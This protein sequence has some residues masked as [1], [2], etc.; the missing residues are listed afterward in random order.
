MPGRREEQATLYLNQGSP[1]E[2]GVVFPNLFLDDVVVQVIDSHNLIGNPNFESGVTTGWSNNGGGTLADSTSQFH[3][4]M[5]S[6]AL[7]ARSAYYNGPSYALPI[8]TAKYSLTL[9]AAQTGSATHDLVLQT[10]YT[11][12]GGAQQYITISTTSAPA[13]TWVA[14]SGTVTMPP[15]NAPADCKLTQ[16]SV[17]LQQGDM[18][19]CGSGDAGDR[20]DRVPGHLHRRRFDRPHTLRSRATPSVK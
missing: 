7:T 13:S 17:Y 14:V 6:L 15:T 12:Q 20:G 2:A 16:A 8:G 4:G 10:S 18:G 19:T 11:C 5:H 1:S 3:A 9:W